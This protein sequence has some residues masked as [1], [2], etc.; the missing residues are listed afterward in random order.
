[1]KKIILLCD[2]HKNEIKKKNIIDQMEFNCD[3]CKDKY[4]WNMV[5]ICKNNHVNNLC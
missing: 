1:M 4:D 3:N 5:F 2:N